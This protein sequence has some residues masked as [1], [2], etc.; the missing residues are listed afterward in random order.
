[1]PGFGVEADD[2]DATVGGGEFNVGV[3][4][5]L[6]FISKSHEGERGLGDCSSSWLTTC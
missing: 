6:H 2:V 1:M 4:Q 3:N 5:P